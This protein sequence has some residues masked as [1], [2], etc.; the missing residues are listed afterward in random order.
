MFIVDLACALGHRFEGWYENARE[1]SELSS[2]G[3]VTC[4]LCGTANVER[5]PSPTRISTTKTRGRDEGAFAAPRPTLPLPLQKALAKVLDHVRRTHEYVGEEFAERALAMHRGEEEPRPIH[6]HA[7]PED[8]ERLD[9]EGVPYL[10]LP[11]PDI[12]KN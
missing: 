6:G 12:E 4:P 5:L 8:E 3:E 1:F 10:K 9:E 2:R 7:S 11:V